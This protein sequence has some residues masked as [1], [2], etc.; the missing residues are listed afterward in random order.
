VLVA[1]GQKL[2]L[3]RNNRNITVRGVEQA[4]R[5]LAEVMGDKRYCISNGWLA[6]LENDVSAPTIWKL[7][8]LSVIYETNISDLLGFYGIDI[9]KMAKLGSVAHQEHT[10]LISQTG[11]L[12][13][14]VVSS[15]VTR[16]V[17]D[18][19]TIGPALPWE[20]NGNKDLVT[21]YIGL[22]DMTMYPLIR[23][24]SFVQVDT[25]QNK[26]RAEKSNN[27]FER[28]I[29]FVELRDGFAC[30]WCELENKQL[31]IMPHPL[32]GVRSRRFMYPREAEIVGRVV[33]YHTRCV[34]TEPARDAKQ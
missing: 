2:K 4:S 31:S 9:N 3:L 20:V 15:A 28:P 30:G 29:F 25:R 17:P 19:R 12:D 21:G 14:Q 1:A 10:H 6:Q 11:V 7:V 34:D 32:S 26:L 27:E 23:P 5:R 13:A 16:L 18:R 24:G 8:S 22:T 33:A